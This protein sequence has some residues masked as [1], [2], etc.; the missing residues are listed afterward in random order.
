MQADQNQNTKNQPS[1]DVKE[2]VDRTYENQDNA[3]FLIRLQAL[4]IDWML[5]LLI[6]TPIWYLIFQ[7]QPG[8]KELLPKVAILL[9]FQIFVFQAIQWI[10]IILL[11]SKIGG[12]LGKIFS[13]IKVTYQKQRL[14]TIGESAFRVFVGYFVAGLLYGLGYLW[15]IR[16]PQN[17]GWHDLASDTLVV[18]WKKSLRFVGTF[19]LL[20]LIFLNS[21]FVYSVFQSIKVNTKLHSEILEIIDDFRSSILENQES[22][23]TIEPQAEEIII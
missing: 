18:Y 3:G 1:V 4:L 9:Y 7:P 13:G 2:F 16:D 12:T 23:D 22:V 15:V 10:Y 5:S 19:I 8:L 17:R 14:L 6:F 20:F 11:T 21:F